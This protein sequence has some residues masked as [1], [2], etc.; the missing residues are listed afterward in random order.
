MDD[1]NLPKPVD[2]AI[3]NPSQLVN[4]TVEGYSPGLVFVLGP[5]GAGKGT[6]CQRLKA[7]YDF[8]HIS[9]GNETRAI[10]T[11]DRDALIKTYD[12]TEIEL[13]AVENL[14]I[15]G[16]RGGGVP[17]E[18]IVRILRK[19]VFVNTDDRL[20]VIEVVEEQSEE[21]A[22]KDVSESVGY[23]EKGGGV[24]GDSGLERFFACVEQQLRH[25]GSQ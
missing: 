13:K 20:K 21:G 22:E 24:E 7:E 15:A 17:P 14:V 6:I 19:R 10:K 11:M 23:V 1:E 5:P 18:I 3:P 25:F 12:F 2:D 8:E 16:V 4:N 9:R